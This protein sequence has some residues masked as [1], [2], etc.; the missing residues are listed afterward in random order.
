MQNTHAHT[1]D[2][3]LHLAPA[4]VREA[5]LSRG[6]SLD[7]TIRFAAF[8]EDMAPFA[9]VAVFGMKARRTGYW[10]PDRY[11]ADLVDRAPDRLIGFASCD[12][13]LPADLEGLREGLE[14]RYTGSST[15]SCSARTTPSPRRASRSRA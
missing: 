7:L 3:T 14:D 10:V 9:K 13:T 12:P 8:M 5:D 11:V 15:S 6:Y 1:W 4:T 2:Q